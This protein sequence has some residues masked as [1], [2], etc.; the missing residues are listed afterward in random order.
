MI[1]YALID[2]NRCLRELASGYLGR[3]VTHATVIT[4]LSLNSLDKLLLI[5]PSV[6]ASRALVPSS[7]R[8][9]SG[10][11]R[12]SRASAIRWR[13]PLENSL[14][15]LETDDTNGQMNQGQL[16]FLHHHM[17]SRSLSHASL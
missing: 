1:S 7:M 15:S 17:E 3:K 2:D 9:I 10:S 13:S 5:E 16:T 14:G 12:N 8:R 4:V 6:V 11:M